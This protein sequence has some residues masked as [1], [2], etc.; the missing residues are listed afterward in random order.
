MLVE[1]DGTM[2]PQIQEIE[3]KTGIESLKAPTE[4]KEANVVVI[5]KYK[6]A[7]LESRWLGAKYGP[8]NEF[9]DYVRKA[10]IRMGHLKAK[11]VVFIADGAPHNWKIQMNNFPYAS[12]ILDFYHAVEHLADFCDLFTNKEQ[13]KRNYNKWYSMLYEGEVLQVIAIFAFQIHTSHR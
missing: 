13:A 5:E 9:N 2:S 3:G 8:R 6:D 12:C 10:G 7:R 1:I 4:Y 11:E